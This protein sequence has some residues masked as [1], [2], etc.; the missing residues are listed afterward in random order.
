MI[1]GSNQIEETEWKLVGGNILKKRGELIDGKD[2]VLRL[3]DTATATYTDTL[4]A[5]NCQ[6]IGL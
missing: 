4:M 6:K 2:G 5:V 1:E 3:K